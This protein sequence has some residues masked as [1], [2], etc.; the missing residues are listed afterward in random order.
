[1]RT[2]KIIYHDKL[3]RI[4]TISA[5]HIHSVTIRNQF[6][7]AN[8]ALISLFPDPSRCADVGLPTEK[9]YSLYHDIV[10]WLND[11]CDNLVVEL[12]TDI[13]NDP[14]DYVATRN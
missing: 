9:A 10:E 13:D 4:H 12:L 14:F 7:G 11:G 5:H 6:Q 2:I 3:S 1:M 8:N